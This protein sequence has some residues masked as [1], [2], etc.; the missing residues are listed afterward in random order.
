[1]KRYSVAPSSSRRKSNVMGSDGIIPPGQ[2]LEQ[3][4]QDTTLVLQQIDRNLS[5]ANTIINNKIK[6]MLQEYGI[7][8]SK[9][10]E[11][12]GFWKHFFE[13]SANVELDSYSEP[14]NQ[15]LPGSEQDQQQEEVE[16]EVH[17]EEGVR[18]GSSVKP[19]MRQYIQDDEDTPTWSTEHVKPS[20][21]SL[22]LSPPTKHR[23]SQLQ[24]SAKF[25]NSPKRQQG[26]SRR[27]R[28]E[29]ML[30]SSPTLP[31]PPVLRS[32]IGSETP[33]QSSDEPLQ[34]FPNTPKYGLYN[35][36]EKNQLQ[37]NDDDDSDLDP[38]ALSSENTKNH[39]R[40]TDSSDDDDDDDELPLPEL[41][42]IE[43]NNHKKF[44]KRKTNTVM[45]TDSTEN[46]FL[47][48]NSIHKET[49]TS[50]DGDKESNETTTIELGP[51]K[52]RYRRLTQN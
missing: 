1:M 45:E 2:I 10:W 47:D 29:Q 34:L 49:T 23:P 41:N 28:I 38:P 16:V 35:S 51:F 11:N 22:Q 48:E 52:E 24:P 8:S 50:R 32:E 31:E 30:N 40:Q 27:S 36:P 33:K 18:V 42:T 37:H 14:L 26:S 46:V 5:R 17:E 44:K 9:V 43:F 39:G 15:S 12:A 21:K 25:S 19:H 7:Q 20:T 3:L 13:Q 6:P 4:D